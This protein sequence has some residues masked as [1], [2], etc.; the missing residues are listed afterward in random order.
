MSLCVFIK[1]SA[2][3]NVFVCVCVCVY[4]CVNVCLYVSCVCVYVCVSVCLYVSCVRLCECM[5]VCVC[6]CVCSHCMYSNKCDDTTRRA[7]EF[8]SRAKNQIIKMSPWG[9]L[10][11]DQYVLRCRA[12]TEMALGLRGYGRVLGRAGGLMSLYPSPAQL[13]GGLSGGGWG[14]RGGNSS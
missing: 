12:N 9:F 3:V 4:V 6:V 8:P 1:L 10:I 5:F 11:R 13:K 2:Y 7:Q 14:R